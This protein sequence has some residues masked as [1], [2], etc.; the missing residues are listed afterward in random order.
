MT[1]RMRESLSA[2][3]DNEANELEMERV[4]K[5]VADDDSLR[6]TW[7]RYNLVRAV[8]AGQP[9]GYSNQHRRGCQRVS[10][11]YAKRKALGEV[12]P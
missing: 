12:L 3:L 11:S 1:E 4:L 8:T 9:G 6:Q 10:S 7:V 5:H 2:L